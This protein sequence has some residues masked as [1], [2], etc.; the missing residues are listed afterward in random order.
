[1]L[2][3]ANLRHDVLK[4]DEVCRGSFFSGNQVSE[5]RVFRNLRGHLEVK[6][7]E[8]KGTQIND[9]ELKGTAGVP[10]TRKAFQG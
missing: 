4:E 1:M 2:W 7:D 9:L 10:F 8:N 5:T 3:V 6:F